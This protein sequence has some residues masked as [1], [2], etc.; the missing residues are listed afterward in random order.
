MTYSSVQE[1]VRDLEAHPVERSGHVYHRIP[2]LEFAHL[3]S[4]ADT[5]GVVRKLELVN[6][7]VSRRIQRG[8]PYERLLDIGANGGLFSFSLAERVVSVTAYEPH[9][10]YGPIGEY[11]A[12][13]RA[14]N[15]DWRA[16][17]FRLEDAQGHWDI[18]LMLSTFQWMTEGDERIAEGLALLRALSRNVTC[19]VFEL[20]LNSGR[21]A[22][23]TK[24]FNHVGAL[25]RLLR[26]STDYPHIK[27]LGAS[28]IWPGGRC[29]HGLRYTFVCSH[30]DGDQEEVWYAPL[31]YLRV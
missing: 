25:Y 4:S 24:R 20:G 2:F 19:L 6:S 3:T 16:R 26:S 17:P 15:V 28:R 8:L 14:R 12:H 31:K 21:S 29:W 18:A 22:L 7:V 23:T 11:L 30:D 10:R 9:P 27:L 5:A 13:A 1:I